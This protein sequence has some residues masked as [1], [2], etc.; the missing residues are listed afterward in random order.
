MSGLAL[1]VIA[2]PIGAGLVVGGLGGLAVMYAMNHAWDWTSE[3][4][5]QWW[6]TRHCRA[7]KHDANEVFQGANVWRCRN[8]GNLTIGSGGKKP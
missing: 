4:V 5:P 8:C 1:F 7:G 6:R 3:R 2:V